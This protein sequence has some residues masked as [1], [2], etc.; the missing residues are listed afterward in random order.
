MLSWRTDGKLWEGYDGSSWLAV[1][2]FTDYKRKTSDESVSSANTGTTL[3]ND[4]ALAWA[5]AASGVYALDLFL[6]Y[7][8]NSTGNLKLGWTFPTS[9]T[10]VY[11]GMH[12]TLAG[13]LTVA[14]FTQASTPAIGGLGADA[15]QHF[16]GMVTNSTNAG[17][18]QLQFAQNTSNAGNTTL[19]AGSYGVLTRLA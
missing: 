17:T 13:A 8:A 6:I 15:P 3:Q 19:K 7:N 16:H 10:M 9:L 4:D 5:V 11:A 1:A 2:R 12:A 18:L 14:S